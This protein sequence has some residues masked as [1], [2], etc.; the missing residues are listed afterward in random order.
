MKTLKSLASLVVTC[1]LWCIPVQPAL[2]Q[3][4]FLEPELQKRNRTA[5]E[6]ANRA[7]ENFKGNSQTSRVPELL[8]APQRRPAQNFDPGQ[9]SQ[10]LASQQ[11]R[12]ADALLVFV[13]LGMPKA[14]LQK[15]AQDSAKVGAVLVLRGLKEASLRK[16]NEVLMAYSKIGANF[17][18]DPE[19]FKKYTIDVVPSFVMVSDASGST[20]T[21]DRCEATS[22]IIE[23]D[24]SIS[25]ALERYAR[26]PQA[27]VRERASTWLKTL[28][29]SHAR[30]DAQ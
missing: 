15:L 18:I 23:G 20:C 7:I 17:S 16:T 30:R 8:K 3:N 29:K 25:Y 1:S 27:N 14:S 4:S 11:P 21:V 10:S 26:D 22:S 6:E 2:A 12:P 19:S 24:V 13:S 28:D 5:L 9:M